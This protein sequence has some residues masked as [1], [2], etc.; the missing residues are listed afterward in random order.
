MNY[1]RL[2]STAALL[3]VLIFP[4]SASMVSFLLI[5]TGLNEGIPATQ[6]GSLWE[7]G[8]MEIFFDAGYIVTNSPITRMEKRP[9]E[10]LGG[11]VKTD[12]DEA[13]EGGA[14]YF[15]LGFLN[16]Q[17]QGRG[18]IPTEITIKLYQTDPRQL[19]FEQSF[20]AGRGK[21]LHEEYQHA[22]S[23]GRAIISQIKDR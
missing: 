7:G 16:Y 9:A 6:Y 23:A 4:A 21:T 17:T 20:P 11:S 13:V 3:L 15:I 1:K 10:D 19:V 14:E 18:A 12:F 22:Q 5:E 8:L 2:G